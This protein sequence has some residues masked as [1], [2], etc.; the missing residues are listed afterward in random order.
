MCSYVYITPHTIHCYTMQITQYGPSHD[1]YC[2]KYRHQSILYIP[3][4]S[5]GLSTGSSEVPKS[6]SSVLQY[7]SMA[8]CRSLMQAISY[9]L[10]TVH[11]CDQH[12]IAQ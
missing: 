5:A 8:D 2:S 9:F 6:Y 10:Y 3:H 4:T 12:G 1:M 11:A 7:N